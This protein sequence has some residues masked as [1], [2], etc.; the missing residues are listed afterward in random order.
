MSLLTRVKRLWGISGGVVNGKSV[1]TAQ[2]P[3]RFFTSESRKKRDQKLATI[4][5]DDPLEDEF[6]EDGYDT[7]SERTPVN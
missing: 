1:Q 4:L 2:D 3:A 6:N 5:Q 7:T